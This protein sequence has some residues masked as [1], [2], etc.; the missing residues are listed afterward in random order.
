[1]RKLNEQ[2][3]STATI[4]SSTTTPS[5]VVQL[6]QVQWSNTRGREIPTV[7]NTTIAAVV[8]VVVAVKAV[9]AAAG[10]ATGVVSTTHGARTIAAWVAGVA[11]AGHTRTLS[12]AAHR[13]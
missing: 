2:T 12:A 4:A 13:R 6:L 3:T 8:G 9:T 10:I 5:N 1:M 7:S 11:I